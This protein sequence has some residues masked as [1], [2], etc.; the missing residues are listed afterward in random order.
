MNQL[1]MKMKLPTVG[2]MVGNQD[3]LAELRTAPNG[4]ICIHGPGVTERFRSRWRFAMSVP[5]SR[6]RRDKPSNTWGA[7]TPAMFTLD[8]RFGRS[9][10]I[11][12]SFSI[13]LHDFASSIA[14]SVAGQHV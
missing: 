1:W 13:R 9:P 6:L 12:S 11:R 5:A 8:F 3:A 14:E 7:F 4:M 2:D 10:R